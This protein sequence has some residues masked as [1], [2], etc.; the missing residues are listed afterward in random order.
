MAPERHSLPAC[1]CPQENYGQVTCIT[2]TVLVSIITWAV[3]NGGSATWSIQGDWSLCFGDRNTSYSVFLLPSWS[4]CFGSSATIP[5]FQAWLLNVYPEGPFFVGC[6]HVSALVFIVGVPG[7]GEGVYF[8]GSD[9]SRM[10]TGSGQVGHIP[11]FPH[12]S[13][14]SCSEN[15]TVCSRLP[16][17]QPQGAL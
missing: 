17:K 9:T 1:R 7:K 10:R 4:S 5:S 14:C 15:S 3:G 16:G 12:C 11:R 13:S 2:K 6:Q 8:F